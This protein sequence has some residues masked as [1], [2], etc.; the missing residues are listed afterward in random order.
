MMATPIAIFCYTEMG[1]L[2]ARETF[3]GCGTVVGGKFCN[4]VG[5][6][7]PKA[8]S[9]INLIRLQPFETFVKSW[10]C[11]RNFEAL[12]NDIVTRDIL[13]PFLYAS[14]LNYRA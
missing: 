12:A 10:D 3:L 4:D 11:Q 8:T 9:V 14:F 5:K 6:Q 13:H 2:V 7:W 1:L